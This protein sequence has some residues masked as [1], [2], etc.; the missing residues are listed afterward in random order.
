MGRRQIDGLGPLAG[1]A[2]MAAMYSGF[3]PHS[4]AQR[5]TGERHESRPLTP[6][7]PEAEVTLSFA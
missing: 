6:S 7:G 3:Q 4:S 2:F 1:G 5:G